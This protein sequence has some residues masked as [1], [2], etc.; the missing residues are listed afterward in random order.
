MANLMILSRDPHKHKQFPMF[1]DFQTYLSKRNIN[2][3]H[4]NRERWQNIPA[5]DHF[6]SYFK[7]QFETDSQFKSVF[8]Y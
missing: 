2:K 8:L 3:I 6:D 1:A 4:L 5:A 7:S